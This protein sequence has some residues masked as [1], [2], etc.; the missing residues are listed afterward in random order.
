[1]R[2]PLDLHRIA[3]MRG[4]TGCGGPGRKEDGQDEQYEE[5]M[6]GTTDGWEKTN[7]MLQNIAV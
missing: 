3:N 1:M 5:E 7:V 2:R 4:E 6:V